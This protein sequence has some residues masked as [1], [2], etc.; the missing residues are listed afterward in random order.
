VD[1]FVDEAV[2]HVSS[3]SGGN[4]AVSFRREKYVPKG[5]PDGGDGGKGG[6]VIFSVRANQK[7]L[8]HLKLKRHF[9]AEN[10]RQGSG[11]GRHGRDGRDVEIGVPPGTQLRNARTG[12]M[13]GDLGEEQVTLVLLRGGRGGKGNAR[14]ATPTHQAPRY[15][16]DGEPGESL[17]V[18][19]ELR[20][21]ADVGLVGMPNAGKST[22]LSVLTKARPK[23]AE[24]PFTT[25]TPNLGLLRIG[26][27]EVVLADVPGIIEGASQ[28]KGLGVR[29]LRHIA[30]CRALMY[31]V[32]L[33]MEHP[34]SAVAV[35]TRELGGYSPALLEKPKILVGTKLDLEGARAGLDKLRSAFPAERVVGISSLTREGL[36]ELRGLILGGA[37]P[38]E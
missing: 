15:A 19:V 21:I 1:G 7:T 30:R 8:S 17:D 28:G 29:F 23:I 24:Y 33:G 35:M 22:L 12:E 32:D 3:G 13:L 4:G 5:G 16:E 10:G 6:D 9:R 14:F 37:G 27:G 31:L 2:I 25:K 38:R 26:E 20:L 36:D 18:E 34:E 11:N